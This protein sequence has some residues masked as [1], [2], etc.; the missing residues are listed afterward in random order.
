MK[1]SCGWIWNVPDTQAANFYRR[2]DNHYYNV[3]TV[4]EARTAI[5]KLLT[6]KPDI[7]KLYNGLTGD[8]VKVI[9]EEAHKKGLKVT[10]HTGGSN[11]LISR[12]SNGQD[13]V[14][15][16]GFDANDEQVLRELRARRTT[17]VPTNINSLAG[18]LAVTEEPGWV[19][20]P[21]ARAQ[22][23]PDLWADIRK[24]ISNIPRMNYFRGEIR[25]R[26]IEE[27]GLSV[28]KLYDAGVRILV[29]TDSGTK[30]NFHTDATWRQMEL[31]VRFGIPPMEVISAATRYAAEYLGMGPELGTIEPSKL[32]DIIVVDGNPLT[33]MGDLKH[34]VYVVKEGVQYKGAATPVSPTQ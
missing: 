7:I 14:E 25:P 20:N 1:M 5:L 34:V 8:Q 26:R 13:A 10:G 17:V 22:T 15:H 32:A 31:L 30:A 3:H 27:Q 12:I 11:D 23:P 9:A 16:M 33:H 24:S 29:G 18:I 19:D 6:Y 28:K 4:Q 2:R 21:R